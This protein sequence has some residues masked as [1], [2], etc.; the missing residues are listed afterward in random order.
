MCWFDIVR[1]M[2]GFLSTPHT[3]ITDND[4][5]SNKLYFCLGLLPNVADTIIPVDARFIILGVFGPF[6]PSRDSIPLG[7]FNDC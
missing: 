4:N 6:F 1:S 2:W 3:R 5:L 7:T